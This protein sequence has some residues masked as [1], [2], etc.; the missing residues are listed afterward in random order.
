MKEGF[1]EK[2]LVRAIETT[3]YEDIVDLCAGIPGSFSRREPDM[4][5]YSSGL[6]ANFLNGVLGPRFSSKAVSKRIE[7]AM[8]RFKKLRLPMRWV[9][10]PSSAPSGLE[11]FLLGKGM[12]SGPAM[13]GMAIDLKIVE[14]EPLPSGLDIRRAEDMKSLR[15]CG[16]TVTKGFEFP[17][18]LAEGFRGLIEGYGISTRHRWFLGIWK[19]RPVAASLLVLH[20]DVAS[21]Y[22]VATVPEAR[23]MGIGTAITREP[24]LEAKNAGYNVAVLEASEMGLPVYEKLGFKE[25][26]EFKT[27]TWSP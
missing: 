6:P 8:A 24:L 1:T 10:G 12:I 18:D 14:S 17:G 5:I 13:P 4:I 2:E 3:Y 19:G 16:K 21:I 27:L 9:L 25:I 20:E 11:G 23:G 26:F 15:T 7:L 22:C